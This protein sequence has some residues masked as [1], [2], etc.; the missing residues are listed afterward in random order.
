MCT[1][2]ERREC[3]RWITRFC[4][5]FWEWQEKG[6]TWKEA[7]SANEPYFKNT[8]QPWIFNSLSPW[9]STDM[10]KSDEFTILSE[11]QPFAKL[12]LLPR[13]FCVILLYN[14]Y[15]QNLSFWSFNT[16]KSRFLINKHTYFDTLHC[17]WEKKAFILTWNRW[18]ITP[19]NLLCALNASKLFLHYC[20]LHFIIHEQRSMRRRTSSKDLNKDTFSRYS[21][22][23][24]ARC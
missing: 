16:E 3:E 6:G 12:P 20:K 21:G 10:K 23:D 7:G 24:P 1:R 2:F 22:G 9:W 8:T 19:L 14:G 13:C 4:C 5:S 18:K 15:K 11:K 17:T